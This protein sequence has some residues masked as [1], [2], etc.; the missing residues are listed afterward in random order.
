M[1]HINLLELD[2]PDR[3]TPNTDRLFV[4]FEP[5]ED[6]ERRWYSNIYQWCVERSQGAPMVYSHVFLLA[7]CATSSR[8]YVL[9]VKYIMGE[10]DNGIRIGECADDVVIIPRDGTVDVTAAFIGGDEDEVGLYPAKEVPLDGVTVDLLLDWAFGM[11]GNVTPVSTWQ[12]IRLW[13]TGD[14]GAYVCTDFVTSLLNMGID[15]VPSPDV[16]YELLG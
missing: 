16:L 12:F 10:H 13:L 3:N 14:C 6:A 7:Y 15:F 9:E 5:V 1:T 8:W 11:A 2:Q 4:C